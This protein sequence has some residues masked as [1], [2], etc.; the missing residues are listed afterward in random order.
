MQNG[1]V[2]N[3]T[4]NEQFLLNEVIRKG[5]YFKKET[6]EDKGNTCRNSSSEQ[7]VDS[8]N[9]SKPQIRMPIENTTQKLNQVK[10]PKAQ[11]IHQSD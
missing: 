8:V 1:K 3:L 2:N 4:K 7:A 11:E 5:D 9:Q 10:S 6:F